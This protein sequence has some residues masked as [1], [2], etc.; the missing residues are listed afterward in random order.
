MFLLVIL[1]QMVACKAILQPTCSDLTGANSFI[2]EEPVAADIYVGLLYEQTVM[3]YESTVTMQADYASWQGNAT[4]YWLQM[5]F[6]QDCVSVCSS[7]SSYKQWRGY[8]CES[9][10]KSPATQLSSWVQLVGTGVGAYD[11]EP[12]I[13]AEADVFLTGKT[14]AAYAVTLH[15]VDVDWWALCDVNLDM[16]FGGEDLL[17][18]FNTADVTLYFDCETWHLTAVFIESASSQHYIKA[19]ISLSENSQTPDTS[20]GNIDITNGSLSEE[21]EMISE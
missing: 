5:A 14:D 13:P 4:V 21:W 16:L 10:S 6:S 20:L 7:D 8:W 9:C 3:A 15:D 1:C 12:C 11:E 18:T 17:Q 19:V 2:A